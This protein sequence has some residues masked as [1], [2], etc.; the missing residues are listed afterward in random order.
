MPDNA[1]PQAVKFC[2]EKARVFADSLLS[3][4]ETARQFDALYGAQSGDTLFPNTADLMA[5]GS[6]VDGRPRVQS[7][8]VRALRTAAQD[9]LTWA[10]TGN[11]TRETRLRS[12]AVNAGSRI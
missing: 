9:L 8:V 5:D 10:G 7:Q 6:D 1:N 4:I 2:N 12:I 3:A 11:P